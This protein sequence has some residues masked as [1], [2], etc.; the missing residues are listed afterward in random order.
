M[1]RP[2]AQMHSRKDPSS[3]VLQMLS[4]M[5]QGST[6]TSLIQK[7]S[8][9]L[10]IVNAATEQGL[11]GFTMTTEEGT[12]WSVI[13]PDPQTPGSFRYTL[14]DRRGFFGHGVY[15]T[16]EAAVEAAFDMGYRFADKA[17]RLDEI[18]TACWLSH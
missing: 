2:S 7:R 15:A 1:I 11:E 16:A 10:A 6:H 13:T 9:W 5:K 12:R 3:V 17:T 4:Q 14:F 8:Q 18:A